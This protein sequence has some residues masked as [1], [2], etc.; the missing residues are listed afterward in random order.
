MKLIGQILTVER[1]QDGLV[2]Q[3][4]G[5]GMRGAVVLEPDIREMPVIGEILAFEFNARAAADPRLLVPPRAAAS[6]Q[7]LSARQQP[8]A[9][10]SARQAEVATNQPSNQ[11]QASDMLLAFMN[12]QANAA[13]SEHDV[14]GELD[15]FVG[16][17]DEVR[18]GLAIRRTL[19]R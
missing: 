8:N 5:G 7:G 11:G 16:T 2:V 18:R 9:S 4:S 15:A 19:T 6:A 12:G 17:P 14:E 13:L 1:S 3:F 10:I